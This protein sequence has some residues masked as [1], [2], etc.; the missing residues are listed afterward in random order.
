MKANLIII[1]LTAVIISC[2]NDS[3]EPAPKTDSGHTDT[4]TVNQPSSAPVQKATNVQLS[5]TL[6]GSWELDYISGPRIAFKGLYPDKKPVLVFEGDSKVT[7]NT[8]C[9]R[10]SGSY[11]Q[12][13]YNIKFG[14]MI[15]TK[16]ACPGNGESVFLSTL[17]KIHKFDRTDDSTLTM[18]MGDIAMMRF[19]KIK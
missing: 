2:N 10:L 9:N 14:E 16:M 12:D 8:S 13:Q 11:T 19:R 17:Q 3:K 5:P 4:P 7:G 6:E 1:A 18:I 15:T